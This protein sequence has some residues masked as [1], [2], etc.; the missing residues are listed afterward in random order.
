MTD[1]PNLT[2]VW[3]GTA[4]GG[5]V[6]DPDTVTAGKFAAGWQAEVP[7]FEYF[8][9]IQKQVTE[10]LAHINE[11]GIAVW[12]DVTTYPVGGLA[13]GSDG[14]VYKALV[15]Q[16]D[17]NP[18]SD[19]GTNWVDWELSKVF[20]TPTVASLKDGGYSVGQAVQTMGL[21]N[22]NDGGG[23]LY[24]IQATNPGT[25]DD[26]WIVALDNGNFAVRDKE[27]LIAEA[28]AGST[29][30][31]G[32]MKYLFMDP[33]EWR[34]AN[35]GGNV[36]SGTNQ[37][38]FFSTAD[39][40]RVEFES[41][42]G[43]MN[44]YIEGGVG[45]EAW[46]GIQQ[47][48][49]TE[50]TFGINPA[51][52]ESLRFVTGFGIGSKTPALEISKLAQ[53][54]FTATA[55][56]VAPLVTVNAQD[57]GFGPI[58]KSGNGSQGYAMDVRLADNTVIF[59]VAG[60]G[61]PEYGD[62]AKSSNGY[63]PIGNGLIMQWGQTSVGLNVSKTVTFPVAF[64][65]AVLQYVCSGVSN[66]DS[67]NTAVHETGASRSTTGTVVFIDGIGA[68]VAG[69]TAVSWFAIGY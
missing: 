36:L 21:E 3:A 6:V 4:P 60:N 56:G 57:G 10:G 68:D 50:W 39:P 18:V 59:R 12:D 30:G 27:L 25:S 47:G 22:E 53:S 69:T 1:K 46:Y 11:Q 8:N 33:A 5:N 15:S 54:T 38:H 19:S 24:S 17:N 9:F 51:I 23:Q 41:N 7:P 67:S 65:N 66:T 37:F 55:P 29:F 62:V 32:T 40:C 35:G 13:K 31:A 49:T 64:P 48:G 28:P 2:R 44:F 20:R 26:A 16:N 63:A 34:S 43:E 45:K 14:N 52:D 58:F 61:T 42:P